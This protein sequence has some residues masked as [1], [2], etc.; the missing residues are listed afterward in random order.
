MKHLVRYDIEI[1]N[2]H[3]FVNE[4]LLQILDCESAYTFTQELEKLNLFHI[5]A[6]EDL[7]NGRD[8][9][10]EYNN[11]VKIVYSIIDDEIEELMH[12]QDYVMLQHYDISELGIDWDA[13][14]RE[15]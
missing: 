2:D 15:G 9:Q 1:N 12:Q 11:G 13:Y 7:Y 14:D 10:Y 3:Q 4:K 6:I 5:T 8:V